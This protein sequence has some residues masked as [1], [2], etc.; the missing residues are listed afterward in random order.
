MFNVKIAHNI[1]RQRPKEPPKYQ[2][3]R[4]VPK[5]HVPTTYI[6]IV[7]S[8]IKYQFWRR[9]LC[10]QLMFISLKTSARDR[11]HSVQTIIDFLFTCLVLPYGDYMTNII[12]EKIFSRSIIPQSLKSNQLQVRILLAKTYT[13]TRRCMYYLSLYKCR[14]TYRGA[15]CRSHSC[16]TRQIEYSR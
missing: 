5:A 15:S 10:K 13:F 16:V 3:L 4:V 12:N 1:L 14:E 2:M 8:N 6:R 11:S 7:F 9:S